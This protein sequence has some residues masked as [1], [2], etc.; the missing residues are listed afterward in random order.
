ME[1]VPPP[2]KELSWE[3]YRITSD[4]ETHCST[5]GGC[6][7]SVPARFSNINQ[8]VRAGRDAGSYRFFI[9]QCGQDVRKYVNCYN[10]HLELSNFLQEI[11]KFQ[12]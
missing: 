10:T 6:R 2:P 8:L 1:E 12:V 5:I 4:C 7:A 11:G 9:K 3:V